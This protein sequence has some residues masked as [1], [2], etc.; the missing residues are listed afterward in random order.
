MEVYGNDLEFITKAYFPGEDGKDIVVDASDFKRKATGSLYIYSPMGIKAGP[1]QVLLEDCSGEK[2]TLP[3][4]TLSDEVVG[5]SGETGGEGYAPIWN[6]DV[7]IYD[8]ANWQYLTSD[9]LSLEGIQIHEGLMIRLTFDNPRWCQC[10][11]M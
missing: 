10:M 7:Y 3:E 5:G 4:V 6:G 1:A 11:R 8:W 2:Y 9:Q